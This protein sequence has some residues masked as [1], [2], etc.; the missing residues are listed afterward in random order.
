MNVLI[1]TQAMKEIANDPRIT[2]TTLAELMETL[3]T[4]RDEDLV[5]AN[6]SLTDVLKLAVDKNRLMVNWSKRG[7]KHQAT[8]TNVTKFNIEF[9]FNLLVTTSAF[10]PDASA[11]L[12]DIDATLTTTISASGV[13][14]VYLFSAVDD[15]QVR[16]IQGYINSKVYS[17]SVNKPPSYGYYSSNNLATSSTPIKSDRVSQ[18]DDDNNSDNTEEDSEEDEDSKTDN[19]EESQD[20]SLLKLSQLTTIEKEPLLPDL[21]VISPPKPHVVA[22]ALSITN[23]FTNET[24]SVN[25][26]ETQLSK[27]KEE[28]Y[29]LAIPILKEGTWY[30]EGRYGIVSFSLTDIT[31]I[32]RNYESNELGFKPP[33]YLGHF[34]EGYKAIYGQGGELAVG[35]LAGLYT[36]EDTDLNSTVL[37]GVFD[38][39]SNIYDAVAKGHY[40]SASGEFL[41][42]ARS[43]FSNEEIGRVLFAHVLSPEPFVPDMPGI[44]TLSDQSIVDSPELALS[45]GDGGY[46]IVNSS[47]RLQGLDGTNKVLV[48]NFEPLSGNLVNNLTMGGSSSNEHTAILGQQD[49]TNLTLEDTM[50]T[51]SSTPIKL[52]ARD[53]SVGTPVKSMQDMIDESNSSIQQLT[54]Q[55][56]SLSQSLTNTNTS[57]ESAH[58]KLT[59]TTAALQAAVEEITA[60]K[61]ENQRLLAEKENAEKLTLCNMI[62][63]SSLA[64]ATKVVLCTQVNEGKLKGEPAYQLIATLS[65]S[66]TATKEGVITTEQLTS[67]VGN[68][69]PQTTALPTGD[70]AFQA[71]I[72]RNK[73]LIENRPSVI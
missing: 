12:K 40:P 2:T 32:I 71:I 65:D 62:Q 34:P 64:E 11:I 49:N 33:L 24:L 16:A 7:G 56:N 6:L 46:A 28:V 26:Y 30:D 43:K 5:S 17:Y 70:S 41:V 9:I 22:D 14:L 55:V 68:L 50:T 20:D 13:E 67:T 8:F 18:T 1:D 31:T 39:T 42:N 57:L 4:F 15:E 73:S 44:Q 29:R 61:A 58:E 3:S 52:T 10:D 38:V 21:G 53:I 27:G 69:T 37:M 60:L 66:R 54:A 35:Y 51:N 45:S 48:F 63:G 59:S 19:L 47:I 25:V 23:P 36:I 72:A